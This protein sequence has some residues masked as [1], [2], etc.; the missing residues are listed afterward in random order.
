MKL[1]N[2]DKFKT[3]QKVILDNQ[4][5]SIKGMSVREYMD[6]NIDEQMAQATT[7]QDRIRLLIEKLKILT[8]IPEDVLFNQEFSVLIALIQVTQGLTPDTPSEEVTSEKK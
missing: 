1:I 7:E 6:N 3:E 5:Y 2:L 8:N 4:E